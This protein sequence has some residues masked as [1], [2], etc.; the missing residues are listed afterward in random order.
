MYFCGDFI[1]TIAM[2]KRFLLVSLLSL[3]T[4][5]VFADRIGPSQA[6]KIASSYLQEDVV[7]SYAAPFRRNTTRMVSDADTLA[8]LY[9]TYIKKYGVFML[10]I[11]KTCVDNIMSLKWVANFLTLCNSLCG[12]AAILYTL[13]VYESP[14][15]S[16]SW[17]ILPRG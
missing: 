7:A 6:L 10:K 12:F 8:P 1:N 13:R 2:K 4:C 17:S 9:I 11:V 3:V 16:A 5:F 14:K 15:G